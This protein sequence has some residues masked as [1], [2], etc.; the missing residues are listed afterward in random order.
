MRSPVRWGNIAMLTKEQ[1]AWLSAALWIN[2]DHAE[3]DAPPEGGFVPRKL[4]DQY[5]DEENEYGWRADAAQTLTPRA[6]GRLHDAKGDNAAIPRDFK[7][8]GK[9]GATLVDYAADPETG[10]MV[11]V[12]GNKQVHRALDDDGDKTGDVDPNFTSRANRDAQREGRGRIEN[13]HDSTMLRGGTAS[14]RTT[15][16]QPKRL[17]GTVDPGSAADTAPVA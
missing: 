4:G 15:S 14:A 5:A 6:D 16:V 9:W 8:D 3:V 11:L 13:I 12:N 10:D 2:I 17:H 1:K 7:D